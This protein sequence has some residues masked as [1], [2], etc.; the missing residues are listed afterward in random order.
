MDPLWLV[1]SPKVCL[2]VSKMT[3]II[4]LHFCR[5]SCVRSVTRMVQTWT[6]L[7]GKGTGLLQETALWG[8]SLGHWNVSQSAYYSTNCHKT[9]SGHF[10]CPAPIKLAECP[11]VPP[12]PQFWFSG[13]GQHKTPSITITL[14][15]V[16]Q[17][18]RS[19]QGQYAKEVLIVQFLFFFLC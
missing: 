9:S 4:S 11:D 10:S 8:N 12:N 1:R 14:G 13:S 18:F 17:Y 16:W 2:Q 7:T 15:Q 19:V 3:C 6:E 5:F